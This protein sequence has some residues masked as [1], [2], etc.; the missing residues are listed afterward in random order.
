MSSW[1]D[2]FTS[3]A[4]PV[5]CEGEALIGVTITVFI[6]EEEEEVG[7]HSGE[8]VKAGNELRGYRMGKQGYWSEWVVV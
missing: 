5:L 1:T 3:V 7:E 8:T 4:C 6:K 2:H